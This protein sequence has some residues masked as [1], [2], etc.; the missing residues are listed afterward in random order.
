MFKLKFRDSQGKNRKAHKVQAGLAKTTK[1]KRVDQVL[2]LHLH[3]LLHPHLHR[4]L[5]KRPQRNLELRNKTEFPKIML[6]IFLEHKAMK[7]SQTSIVF[8][9]DRIISQKSKAIR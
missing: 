1:R 4:V 6:T 2:L 8:R 5:E 9:V 7:R 3:H